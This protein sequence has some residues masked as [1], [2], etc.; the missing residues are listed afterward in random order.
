MG[1]LDGKIAKQVA[2]AIKAAKLDKPATLIKV[3][4]GAHTSGALSAG[5]NPTEASY[6]CRGWV[7]S[8]SSYAIANSLASA[9][10]RKVSLLGASLPSGIVPADTDKITIEGVTYRILQITGRDPAGAVY[11]CQARK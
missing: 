11:E 8:Y 5:M 4:N 10:D 2:K 6:S 3:T 7:E 1:L 9:Q